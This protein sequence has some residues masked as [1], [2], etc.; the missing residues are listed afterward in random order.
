MS[1]LNRLPTLQ[2]L[3]NLVDSKARFGP[4]LPPNPFTNV[5]HQFTGRLY[6]CWQSGQ[7][8]VRDFDNVQVA[9]VSKFDAHFVWYVR[10]GPG[11][12]AQ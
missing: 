1:R 3:A 2:E 6:R 8:V 5:R 7:R 4:T 10:G 9:N 11:V 12:D